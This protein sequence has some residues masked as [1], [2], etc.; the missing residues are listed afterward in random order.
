MFTFTWDSPEPTSQ[1]SNIQ[2]T[3]FPVLFIYDCFICRRLRFNCVA[4]CTENPIYVLLFWELHS[5]SPNFHIHVFVSDFYIPWIGPH[6]VIGISIVWIYKSLT[7]TWMWKLGL[8]PRNSFS[9]NI[10]F[11][12]LVLFL[13][14][15]GC[16]DWTQDC[17]SVALI[18]RTSKFSAK[19]QPLP[20]HS[21]RKAQTSLYVPLYHILANALA[22]FPQ[23]LCLRIF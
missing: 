17:C 16:S 19:S 11:E 4:H 18:V 2:Y 22:S 12:F 23:F 5:L 6:K 15:V 10:C 21:V 3:T 20:L 14:S 9:G 13:W 1:N 8:W 7:D